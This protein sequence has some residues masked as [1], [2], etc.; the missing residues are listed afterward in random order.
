MTIVSRRICVGMRMWL[1]VGC[2]VHGDGMF[3]SKT[4]MYGKT[5]SHDD[6]MG[7]LSWG[8]DEGLLLD[9]ATA[10]LQTRLVLE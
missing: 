2:I 1:L 8:S 3:V 7:L 4:I 10:R 5:L 6:S 9:I